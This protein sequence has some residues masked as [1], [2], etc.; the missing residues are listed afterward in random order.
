MIWKTFSVCALLYFSI[1]FLGTYST[2][3]NAGGVLVMGIGWF[4]CVEEINSIEQ[5]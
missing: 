4:V 1:A 5:R 3:H 2:C